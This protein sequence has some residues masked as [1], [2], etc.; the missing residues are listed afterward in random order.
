VKGDFLLETR[1]DII[2]A[3]VQRRERVSV[4]ELAQLLEVSTV[5]IRS[6]LEQLRL[7]GQIRRT[8]GGATKPLLHQMEQPLEQNRKQNLLAKRHIAEAAAK[9]IENGD[10]IFVDVG[11]TTS[12]MVRFISTKLEDVTVITNGLNIA[13]ELERLANLTIVV[14]GGTLRTLQHSLVNPLGMEMLKYLHPNKVFLG[15]NGV[16]VLSGITNSN[17]PE[18]EIK[19]EVVKRAKWVYVLA[20]HSKLGQVHPATIA[21]LDQVTTLITDSK[22][23]PEE[24]LALKQAGLNLQLV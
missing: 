5:T 20:D 7:Q 1:L 16:S 10:V 17:L 13:L 18:A 11:S 24:V 15:C 6:D 22:A 9:R 3:E 4:H 8:R 23:D 12:E 19:R 14:T 2:L 21:S